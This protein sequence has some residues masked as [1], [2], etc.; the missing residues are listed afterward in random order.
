M[1][2]PRVNGAPE[3]MN[4]TNPMDRNRTTA[5]ALHDLAAAARRFA[6]QCG[7]LLSESE[8]EP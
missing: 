4:C 8:G 1:K 3:P 6:E 7:P 2:R 5:A